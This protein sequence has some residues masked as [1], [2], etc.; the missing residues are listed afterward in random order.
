MTKPITMFPN[1]EKTRNDMPALLTLGVDYKF[2]FGLKAALGF[3]YYWD[4]SADYG[5]KI[6]DDIDGSTPS[7]HIA[8]DKIIGDNGFSFS[9]GLEYPITK[10]ILVSGGYVWANQG[11]NSTYQSD[12]NYGLGTQTFGFGAAYN[13]TDKIQFIIGGSWT[14]YYQDTKIINHKLNGVNQYPSETY[15]KNTKLIG[16]GL[17][18][19]F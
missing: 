19:S 17:E 1:G 6:D 15:K 9:G 4:K 11:V 16:I 5:H 13:I 7:V 8:N 2:S 10:K 12:L 14:A 18:M 3:N